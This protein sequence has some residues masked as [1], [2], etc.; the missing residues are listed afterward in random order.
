MCVRAISDPVY[1]PPD[2]TIVAEY[3]AVC[4]KI[5]SYMSTF[6]AVARTD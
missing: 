3:Q 1:A 5:E 2:P 6:E 4:T